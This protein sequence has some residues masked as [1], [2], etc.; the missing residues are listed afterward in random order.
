MSNVHARRAT[1]Q[2][3]DALRRL[4][5]EAVAPRASLW[6]LRRERLDPAAWLAAHAPVVVVDDHSTDVAF[7]VAVTDG[8]PLGA[9]RCAEA[10][11][12]VSPAHR[13]HGAARAALTE[14]LTVCRTMGLWK[15]LAYALPEDPAARALFAR[16]DFRDVGTLIK[17]VQVDSSWHDVVL[18]E[19]LVL[20]AR[21]SQ[22]SIPDA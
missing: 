14:L 17:H 18:A 6:S 15:L 13:R 8:I 10:F 21:K 3:V 7:A 2:D 22:P 16:M 1:A 4:H 20:A 5:A 19:R 12:F 9:P 11:V